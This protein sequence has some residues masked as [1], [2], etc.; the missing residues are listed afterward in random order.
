M[1]REPNNL[2]KVTSCITIIHDEVITYV[3][4][5][6]PF[7]FILHWTVSVVMFTWLHCTM[8]QI[9]IL[10][11]SVCLSV[12]VHCPKV[13][14][15]NLFWWNLQHSS[16][17]GN[18]PPTENTIY[19]VEYSHDQWRHVTVNGDNIMLGLN[20]YTYWPTSVLSAKQRRLNA[21]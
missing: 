13:T 12:S 9:I 2:F 5:E 4:T 14:I 3:C 1:S 8:R 16:E 17:P 18:C 10:L 11:S 6:Q 21:T 19:C 20:L 15:F 7:C